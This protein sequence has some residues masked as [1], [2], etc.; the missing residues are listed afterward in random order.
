MGVSGNRIVAGRAFIIVDALDN[1]NRT[2]SQIQQRFIRFGS[3]MQAIGLNIM[4]A[5]L[6]ALTPAGLSLKVFTDFDDAMR[7][8]EARSQGTSK[9]LSNLR[10]QAKELGRTTVFTARQI[11]GLQSVLAQRGFN[12]TQIGQMTG[13][14]AAL[15]R[16]GGTGNRGQD[17]LVAADVTS[18]IM[19][20]MQMDFEQTGHVADVLTAAV[21]ES[22]FTLQD[23][24]NSMQ[25]SA[26]VA[27]QYG[28]SLEELTA[29]LGAMRNLGIDPGIAGT[30]LRN[31]FLKASNAKNV[32][33]LNDQLYE[34]TGNTVEFVDAAG[35]LH[36]PT[37]IIFNLMKAMEGLGTAQQG[38]MLSEVF[39]LRAIVPATGLGRAREEFERLIKVM[40]DVDG[41][42]DKTAAT[43]DAGI[44]GSIRILLSSIEGIAI[45]LDEALSPAIKTLNE[46]ITNI[47]QEII[48]WI[49]NNQELVIMFHTVGVELL[50]VG[51]ALALVGTAIKVLAFLLSPII[52]LFSLFSFVLSI[53]SGAISLVFTLI[54]SL[55]GVIFSLGSAL[56][57]LILSGPFGAVF[58][59]AIVAVGALVAKFIELKIATTDW[60]NVWDSI[61]G[62]IQSGVNRV[63]SLVND[64][65]STFKQTHNAIAQ[66]LSLGDTW[67]AWQIFV[68]GVKLMWIQLMNYL[69]M[70]IKL[71]LR[72]IARALI[73][74]AA[75]IPKLRPLVHQ[76]VHGPIK[77]LINAPSM[78][79][80]PTGPAQAGLDVLTNYT[81]AKSLASRA[82]DYLSQYIPNLPSLGA[83]GAG[84]ANLIVHGFGGNQSSVG[85][86][87]VLGAGTRQDEGAYA[88]FENRR[89]M[90]EIAE[91]NKDANSETAA[92]TSGIF[93]K[94]SN[95]II[96]AI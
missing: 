87:G 74:T 5:G 48:K 53:V 70:T 65:I 6:A 33:K 76:I 4:K 61:V 73:W 14:I 45:A 1:T 25:L 29:V 81:M 13:P 50:V 60:G 43:M 28:M 27:A 41:L 42:A 80:T 7:Q 56:G 12:R 46:H 59:L 64:L 19:R 10:I 89:N 31:M 79:Q 63:K 37:D 23:L 90:E 75:Y 8:V 88:L 17:I 49:E 34:L 20:A 95:W 58:A 51:G 94:I 78:M 72:D 85:I 3:R 68:A 71:V 32:Q 26:P 77:N 36:K 40:N 93:N 62:R 91:A 21:N 84:I 22:N 16:A 96:E 86:P 66:A 82:W 54:T 38:S 47:N 30:G 15:A 44:G 69:K 35:N 52:A 39:G 83:A 9:E 2:L 18:N 24:M 55:I 57:G 67:L 11:A 92:N